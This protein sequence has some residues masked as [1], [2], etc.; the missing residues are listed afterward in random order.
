MRRLHLVGLCA[1]LGIVML[2]LQPFTKLQNTVSDLFFSSHSIQTPITIVAIDEKSISTEGQ[3]GRFKDWP[4]T[5]YAQA[6]RELNK[7]EPAVVG[8]DLDFRERSQGI[9][10]QRLTQFADLKKSGRS[11]ID[12]NSIIA[13][14]TQNSGAVSQHPDDVELQKTLDTTKRVVLVEPLLIT[15]AGEVAEGSRGVLPLV[16]GSIP[17][18]FSGSSIFSGFN[19]ASFDS[20]GVVRRFLS[21]LGAKKSFSY[22]LAQQYALSQ[23]KTLSEGV[24]NEEGY[25]RIRFLGKPG[26]TFNTVSFLDLVNGKVDPSLIKNHIV[27]IGGTAGILHD[28]A[29]TLTGFEPMPG[30]E[31]LATETQ[32]ILDG[33]YMHESG[34]TWKIVGFVLLLL[35]TMLFFAA[36]TQVFCSPFYCVD[37]FIALSW[38]YVFSKRNCTRC[39]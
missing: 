4:R 28:D 37:F 5:Y 12:W 7:F 13:L 32:Q 26:Q 1:V 19:T 35:I 36:L 24:F 21:T 10:G 23:G 33:F 39:C 27:I 3:L 25:N 14:F 8:I 30:V 29:L 38:I 9:S 16:N 18:I 20:D 34:L 6:I 22:V 31:I 11:D 17:P 2:F 15:D